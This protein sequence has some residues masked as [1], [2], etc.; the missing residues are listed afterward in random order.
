MR[1]NC[2]TTAHISNNQLA[3]AQTAL[4]KSI[5]RLSSGL[6]INHAADDAAGMAI[7]KR[8]HTQ[9]KALERA[10]KNTSDG[11]AVVQTAEGA[12]GEVENMLQRIRELAVQAADGTYSDEDRAAIQ[13]EIDQILKEVDR[14]STD[15]EYNTMPLLDGTLSR[16]AYADT[17]G[18]YVQSMS[19]TVASKEYEITVTQGSEAPETVLNLAAITAATEGNMSINGVS[20]SLKDGDTPADLWDK[21]YDVCSIAGI[22]VENNGGQISLK[23]QITG[24]GEAIILRFASADQANALA[25]AGNYDA[26]KLMA[27]VRGKD[28][29][30]T[31]G[32]GF[33]T[34]KVTAQGNIITIRDVNSFEMVVEV[35]DESTLST[36]IK[37][38]DMGTLNIQAGANEGQQI[39]IDI[40]KINAHTLG[41]DKINCKTA[42]GA[43]KAI[44]KLD[45]AINR[46]SSAR[47]KLGAY[48]NRLETTTNS[49]DLFDENMTS[50]LSTIE[51][52]DMAD[53]MTEYTAKSV[54]T[55]AATSVLAQANERPQTVLQLL[56]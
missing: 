22:D 38:T 8:M 19:G 41:I 12:L 43:S 53:E 56:Q 31:L 21:I 40:P 9:I 50:A 39:V 42:Y 30:V 45:E 35:P 13:A 27:E 16:R 54:L 2:N 25:G 14:V 4:D 15:T 33:D 46:V 5:E 52:C 10:A 18:V 11:V 3:K 47:S 32:N 24:S 26:D 55:Q 23:G 7:A 1:V 37:V 29:E 17:D 6:K 48:Q 51:D 44:E 34:A 28:C 36:T 49:L 20:V